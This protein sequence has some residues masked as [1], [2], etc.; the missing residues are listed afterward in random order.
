MCGIV[1]F[2]RTRPSATSDRAL[3]HR[4]VAAIRHRGPDGE[5][6]YLDG[7]AGLGHARLSIID[8]AG[9]QQPMASADGTL[10]VSFNGEIF[11]YVEL[12]AD[13]IRRGR[14]FCTESDTEVILH[15]YDEMGADCVKVMNGDFAFAIWD[16]RR[17]RLMLARDRMGVRPLFYTERD[18][19]LY[20]ASEGK[21][22]I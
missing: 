3:L 12:R 4:M 15:L 8:I 6:V 1:G 19:A 14:R 17:S 13:L 9:G 20:F 18:G 2:H 16:S 7:P 21:A 22:L 5:G 10:H 11:N